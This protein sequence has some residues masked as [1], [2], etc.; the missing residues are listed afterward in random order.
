MLTAFMLYLYVI[1]SHPVSSEYRPEAPCPPTA[2]RTAISLTVQGGP[3]VSSHLYS[4]NPV[5]DAVLS[6]QVMSIRDVL[7]AFAVRS[8]GASMVEVSDAVPL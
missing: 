7:I 6:V 1:P 2:G 4:L 5:S 8:L 3:P